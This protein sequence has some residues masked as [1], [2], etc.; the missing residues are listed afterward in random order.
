MFW[1]TSLPAQ[2]YWEK[3]KEQ[4]WVDPGHDDRQK[5]AQHWKDSLSTHRA[6]VMS[7]KQMAPGL[8]CLT[9]QKLFTHTEA[10][11]FWLEDDFHKSRHRI[12]AFSICGMCITTQ[13]IG[14]GQARG[15]LTQW[16]CPT[17]AKGLKRVVFLPLER[18]RNLELLSEMSHVCREGGWELRKIASQFEGK[19]S[20]R[21]QGFRHGSTCGRMEAHLTRSLK[22]SSQRCKQAC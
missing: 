1:L 15:R 4:K 13:A 16:L 6:Y 2:D 3:G 14:V 12:H 8:Q 5:A 21:T 17:T 7:L 18:G 10:D 19:Y 9:K 20:D 11:G 22:P